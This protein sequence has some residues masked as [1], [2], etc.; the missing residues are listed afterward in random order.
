M[1]T[2]RNFRFSVHV[3]GGPVKITL[4]PGQSLEHGTFAYTDEGYTKESYRWSL[5][6]DGSELLREWYQD[7]RDCD[8]RLSRS[9]E[10]CLDPSAPEFCNVEIVYGVQFSYPRFNPISEGQRDYS[11]EAMGY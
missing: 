10:D 5:A 11:A 1:S 9:G 4:R 2:K 8:G 7:G 6:K 3:N